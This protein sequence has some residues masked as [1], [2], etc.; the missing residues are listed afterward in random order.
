MLGLSQK[1]CIDHV[2]KRNSMNSS[3]GDAPN[4]KGD[5]FFKSGHPKND[6]KRQ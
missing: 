3:P 6:R 2:I 5:K 4:A 1:A